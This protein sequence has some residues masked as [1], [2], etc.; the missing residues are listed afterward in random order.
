M[1][2][3]SVE[4]ILDM[5]KIETCPE[6]CRGSPWWTDHRLVTRLVPEVIAKQGAVT[7]LFP[8]TSSKDLIINQDTKNNIMNLSVYLVNCHVTICHAWA[9]ISEHPTSIVNYTSMDLVCS[10]FTAYNWLCSVIVPSRMLFFHINVPISWK[11]LTAL[12]H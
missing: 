8:A 10:Y 7:W 4:T 6:G 9:A 1:K 3:P 2:M 11:E 5:L 12:W